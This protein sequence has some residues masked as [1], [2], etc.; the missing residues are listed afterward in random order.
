ML[1]GRADWIVGDFVIDLKYKMYQ[2]EEVELSDRN[3]VLLYMFLYNK[4]KG[5]VLYID[6][7]GEIRFHTVERDE[8]LIK[9][10]LGKAVKL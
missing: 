6:Q 9:S 4:P 5:I 2:P 3:Q 8:A 7:Y 10:L 1:R